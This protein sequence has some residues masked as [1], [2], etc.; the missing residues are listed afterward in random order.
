MA[1]QFANRYTDLHV[2]KLE[3]QDIG[4]KKLRAVDKTVDLGNSVDRS[5]AFQCSKGQ[6]RGRGK[7]VADF[8]WTFRCLS[9]RCDLLPAQVAVGPDRPDLT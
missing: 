4:K 1:T 8:V 2:S 6:E 7:A 3:G 9:G 5:S